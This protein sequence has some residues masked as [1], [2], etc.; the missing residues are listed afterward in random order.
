[1][2]AAVGFWPRVDSHAKRTGS[3]FLGKE[4]TSGQH[5]PLRKKGKSPYLGHPIFSCQ[6]SYVKCHT[7]ESW[8]PSTRTV[9]RSLFTRTAIDKS[10]PRPKRKEKEAN[11]E[12]FAFLCPFFSVKTHGARSHRR[13]GDIPDETN[14]WI[15]TVPTNRRLN[16]GRHVTRL[17]IYL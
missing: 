16:K 8:I 13:P 3:F 9:A 7:V 4:P 10:P 1:M 17:S 15:R 14:T 12:K 5:P 11:T 6:S 2:V